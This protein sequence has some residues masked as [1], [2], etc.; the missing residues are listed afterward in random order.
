[1]ESKLL[2]QTTG[3]TA[4]HQQQGHGQISSFNVKMTGNTN[5]AISNQTAGTGKM[6]VATML[7]PRDD[8]D[9]RHTRC[10]N[11]VMN[12]IG[13][14]SEKEAHDALSSA[15]SKD[16]K[17]H[18]EVCLGF[19]VGILTHQATINAGSGIN[20]SNGAADQELPARYYRDLTLVARDGLQCVL[21]HLTHLATEKYLKMLPA[22]KQQLMW[23]IRELIRNN[24]QGMDN[25]CWNLMRQIA[26]GDVSRNN[27][28]LADIMVD[29][30]AEHRAWV[31]KHPFLVASVVYTFLRLIEDHT[32]PQYEKLR[33]KE[34]KFVIGLIRDKFN[35]VITIGRDLVRLLQ[36]VAKIPEFEALWRDILYKPKS[37]SPTFSWFAQLMQTRTSR[38]FLQS[39]ITPEM[40]KKMVFFTGQVFICL[41]YQNINEGKIGNLR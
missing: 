30:L 25:V 6:F 21:G 7:E 35:D 18:E 8:L 1:M 17:T 24:V 26:G 22:V 36:Y 37:L 19:V 11:L 4:S 29:I 38:R 5:T 15:V 3:S 34:V 20:G 16:P 13:D 12:L 31:E 2:Q 33:D 23:L 27:L 10:Y 9:D 39:R 14:K 32:Q 41:H 40:E 28:W